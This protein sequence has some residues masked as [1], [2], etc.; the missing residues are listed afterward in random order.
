LFLFGE[1]ALLLIIA[2]VSSTPLVKMLIEKIK[3]YRN[4]YS[5]AICRLGEKIFIPALLILSIAFI[6]D[7]S[8]NPFLYFRF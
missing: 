4:G 1:Y 3:S 5:L 7:A 8:Y 2:A 6:V